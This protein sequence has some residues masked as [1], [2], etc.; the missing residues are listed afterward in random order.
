MT[1]K[2]ILRVGKI[3]ATGR[4]TP[5]SVGGHLARSRPTPNADGRKTPS[6][7]WIVGSADMDLDV[8]IGNVMQRAGI[9]RGALRKDAVLANDV[10]LTIS[11]EWFRPDDPEA[12]GKYDPARLK[13]FK[14]EAEAFLVKTFGKARVA[15]AVL[16]LDEATPHIQAVIVPVMPGKTKDGPKH[17]LSS[18]DMFDPTRLAQLQQDWEDRLRPHGVGPREKHSRARH[19]TLREYYGAL[20]ASRSDDPRPK[21]EI[22]TPPAK[23][24]FESSATHGRRVE[25][26]RKD[27]AKRIREELR[28]LAKEASRGRLYDAE[29]RSGIELRTSLAYQ[30]ERLSKAYEIMGKDDA[31]I[32]RLRGAPLNQVAAALGYDGPVGKKEN[33]IDLVR[34]VG[35]LDY[36]QAVAWLAQNVSIDDAAAAVRDAAARQIARPAPLVLTKGDR[37]KTKLVSQQLTAIAAPAYRITAMRERGGEQI[38]QNVGKDAFGE[39]RLTKDQVLELVPRL[40]ALNAGGANVFITPLEEGVHHVLID[41]LKSDGLA[42]LTSRGYAP[43]VVLETS[44]GNHQAVLKVAAPKAATNEWFKDLNRDIGDDRIVGLSHPLRLAGFQNRKEKHQAKDGRFPF[45]RL[46]E[47][48][49]RLCGRSKAVVAAYVAQL[50]LPTKRPSRGP[51]GPR[52]Q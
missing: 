48:V 49:N 34:R 30:G 7:V 8:A 9:D 50:D 23:K 46:V 29:R 19:T 1:A 43:A 21:V 28:P 35:E 2:P 24:A 33:A 51:S 26:W 38:G 27:E 3:K 37:M 16:H 31:E 20:E 15:A 52:M 12:Y 14:A 44:P 11:P 17:R 36:K 5:G 39:D 32:R 40:T 6:N 13:V 47:A 18:K 45:V 10:L 41:D 4:S 22:S 25:T 42:S